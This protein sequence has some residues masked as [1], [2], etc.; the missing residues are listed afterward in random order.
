MS[1]TPDTTI[2]APDTAAAEAQ[3]ARRERFWN[4]LTVIIIAAMILLWAVGLYYRR[5]VRANYGAWRLAHAS[6]LADR[7]RWADY[8]VAQ[9]LAALSPAIRLS[10]DDRAA[11]RAEAVK[12]LVTVAR[13]HYED[14][15]EGHDSWPTVTGRFRDLLDDSDGEVRI[16]AVEGVGDVRDT[17]SVDKLAEIALTVD[18]ATP[19]EIAGDEVPVGSLLGQRATAR[20]A[21]IGP[22]DKILPMLKRI[23]V[24]AKNP[25]VRVQAI[26]SV[27]FDL[28]PGELTKLADVLHDVRPVLVRPE[29][30]MLAMNPAV[31]QM[32]GRALGE[33]VE[34]ED[35]SAG[36]TTQPDALGR[37]P[38]VA[39]YA[40]K[41]LR[42]VTGRE[43]GFDAHAPEA[44]REAAIRRWKQYL[45]R[46]GA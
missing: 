12:V 13:K 33:G 35:P 18:A 45:S 29:S 43:F 27:W 34:L 21:Q 20:L 25:D 5:E 6:T 19:A 30:E 32:I 1:R 9:D 28:T 44:D 46:E 31:Q 26:D 37:R 39:D 22:H 42:R 16:W 17:A 3:A 24:E 8:M 23:L 36:P 10:R 41:V 38:T 4:R 2:P 14:A 40:V 7:D 15:R 11:V